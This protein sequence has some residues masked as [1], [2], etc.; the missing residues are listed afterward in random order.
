MLL[1]VEVHTSLRAYLREHS[2]MNWPHY[3][4]MARLIARTLRLGRSTL[5]QTGTEVKRY[6][7]SYLIPALLSREAVLLVLPEAWQQ[8]YLEREIPQL[9]KWLKT[10]KTVIKGD[11]WFNYAGFSGLIVTSPQLWLSDRLHNQ[12]LFPSSVPTLID[13]GG[14]LET[15]A[16]Q[17]L[18]FNLTPQD[19]WQQQQRSPSQQGAIATLRMDI[20]QKLYQNPVN[21]YNCYALDQMIQEQLQAICANLEADA[22]LSPAFACFWHQWQQPEQ[23]LW[24][25]LDRSTGK[26]QLY[27]APNSVAESLSRVWLQQPIVIM[28]RFLDKEVDASLYRAALGLE[29]LLCLHFR[30]D[31]QSQSIQLY[32]PDRFP[33]PNTPQFQPALLRELSYLV[34]L[35][36]R[37]HRG[38]VILVEDVPLKAQVAANLAAEF[39]S[40]VQ[41]ET[42]DV[43]NP[44]I[45]VSGWEFWRS[46]QNQFSPPHLLI[47]ATLPL[48]S[49]ENPVVA[50]QVTYY[51]Q[52]RLDWFR[53]YLLPTALREMQKAIAPVRDSQGMLVILDNRVN[54][55]SYGNDILQAL[56]PCDRINR[57][58]VIDF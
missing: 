52:K 29:S 8:Q 24:A 35:A 48:P 50:S 34:N 33:F 18:T 20:T 32:S 54:Y 4:T 10:D 30:P 19:W 7:I 11:K 13:Q 1:E 2:E 47:I 55:R 26:F 42:V 41:L 5:I 38:V 39:G 57:P 37:T 15:W 45:L 51:K 58:S 44:S 43:F 28:D 46:Y 25:S 14:D 31:R 53:C 49:L 6:S 27:L 17:Q 12:G 23:I 22:S 3:L 16:R 40:R 21:P 9:Q 56:E 36:I